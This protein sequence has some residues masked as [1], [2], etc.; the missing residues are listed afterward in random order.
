MDGKG[1]ATDNINIERFWR[2][3]KQDWV[4][5]HPADNGTELWA[6]INWY[7]NFYNKEKTHQGIGRQIPESVYRKVA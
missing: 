7:I 4:Y 6:G 3:L 5:S 2:T 1:R